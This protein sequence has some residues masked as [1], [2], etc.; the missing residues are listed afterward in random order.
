MALLK[1]CS[2]RSCR[3]LVNYGVKFC[4]YHQVKYDKEQKERYKEYQFRRYKDNNKKK[5]QQFYSS[6][7][8]KNLREAIKK[9]LFHID[10]LEYYRTGRIIEGEAVH[11][12]LEVEE[13]WES[14]LD[15]SNLIYLTERNHKR[16]HEKYNESSKSKKKMQNILLGLLEQFYKDFY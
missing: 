2:F 9:E 10:I 8:W 13:D 7:P 16:V 15:I 11:H 5:S 4:E 3:K 1:Q 12:I 14:R 6:V